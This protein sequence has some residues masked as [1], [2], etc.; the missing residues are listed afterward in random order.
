[1]RIITPESLHY[2][3]TV[4][5]LLCKPR[6]HVDRNAPLFDYQYKSSVL[7]GDEDN[8]EGKLVERT[9]PSTFESYVEGS[10]T[11]WHVAEGRV[12]ARPG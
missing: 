1:M 5:R 3:I 11:Q 2:P 10:L 6:D 12:I 8:R 4:T 9:W 7:E